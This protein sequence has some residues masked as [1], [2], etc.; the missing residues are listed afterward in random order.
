MSHYSFRFFD[1]PAELR[2]LIYIN[3]TESTPWL[4]RNDDSAPIRYAFE[5]GSVPHC[6]LVSKRFHREYSAQIR[7]TVKVIIQPWCIRFDT[8]LVQILSFSEP[9][10][11]VEVTIMNGHIGLKERSRW[12]T[13]LTNMLPNIIELEMCIC[14]DS[15]SL[16]QESFKGRGWHLALLADFDKFVALPFLS[17]LHVMRHRVWYENSTEARVFTSTSPWA[18][19]TKTLR[20]Q[21]AGTKAEQ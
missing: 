18:T 13:T 21:A 7:R 15:S 20:W 8:T 3:L 2:D 11:Q 5:D 10:R 14:V 6:L 19:W 4:R 16:G 12:L 9:I 17:H 1:L